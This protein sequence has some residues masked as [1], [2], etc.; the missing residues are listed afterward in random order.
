MLLEFSTSRLCE[1]LPR[2]V[3]FGSLKHGLKG[4]LW[5]YI[6]ERNVEV[7]G[8][9]SLKLMWSKLFLSPPIITLL[10]SER[11]N[12]LYFTICCT[13]LANFYRGTAHLKFAYTT[14]INPPN[15]HAVWNMGSLS[16][17]SVQAASSQL[18]EATLLICVRPSSL[19]HDVFAWQRFFPC[20]EK[21]QRLYIEK[22]VVLM[23]VNPFH[24]ISWN[25]W[26]CSI[27]L[28][29]HV[30][31]WWICPDKANLNICFSTVE[32]GHGYDV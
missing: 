8:I 22:L 29:F 20:S 6:L 1:L 25:L 31:F 28:L 11:N 17:S 4:C 24:P 21:G 16:I 14:C 27:Q 12:L 15:A 2:V 9:V 23:L 30:C 7:G 18:L 5:N 26:T 13:V 19:K 32:D 3:L 10:K